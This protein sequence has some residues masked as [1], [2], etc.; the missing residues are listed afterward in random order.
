MNFVQYFTPEY[1]LPVALGLGG[2][3]LYHL[4]WPV[5][6]GL[7]AVAYF[8]AY[9]VACFVD[10]FRGGL[11]DDWSTHCHDEMRRK[12]YPKP[13]ASAVATEAMI[14]KLYSHKVDTDALFERVA[15][16]EEKDKSELCRDLWNSVTS[17]IMT[18]DKVPYAGGGSGY[19]TSGVDRNASG[20]PCPTPVKPTKNLRPGDEVSVRIKIKEISETSIRCD[21]LPV[22]VA[23]FEQLDALRTDK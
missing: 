7:W 5:M 15:A 3:A 14:F 10:M 9:V 21:T 6:R 12:W 4:F 2:A 23:T 16:L 13:P 1:L 11:T 20:K 8:G 18:Y 17:E 22:Y 19:F